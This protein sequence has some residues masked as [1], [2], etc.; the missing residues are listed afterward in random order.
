MMCGR[1][2]ACAQ[3]HHGALRAAQESVYEKTGMPFTRQPRLRSRR[4]AARGGGGSHALP[5]LYAPC[6]AARA[7]S[8]G[9]GAPVESVVAGASPRMVREVE[10]R[11]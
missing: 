8:D 4:Q 9:S 5:P 3:K 2:M 6:A 10:Q 11:G 7:M 1:G